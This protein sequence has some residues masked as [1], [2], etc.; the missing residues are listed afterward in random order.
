MR[1]GRGGYFG[2]LPIL[3]ETISGTARSAARNSLKPQPSVTRGI[4][5]PGSSKTPWLLWTPGGFR[6][7]AR[8]RRKL[9]RL[10]LRILR[11]LENKPGVERP[12]PVL[13][14]F[15]IHYELAD[16]TLAIA[17]GDEGRRWRWGAIR[18]QSFRCCERRPGDDHGES[19]RA[20]LGSRGDA[21]WPPNATSCSACWPCRPA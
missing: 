16:H 3:C 9:N 2:R 4:S 18:V 15:N 17:P 11:G 7:N 5:R 21:P 13:A 14:A 8:L 1:R 19:R 6:V 10:K 20:A 12:E